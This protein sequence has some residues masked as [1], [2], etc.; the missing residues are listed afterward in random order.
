[1]DL[2][3]RLRAFTVKAAAR[4]PLLQTEEAAKTALVMPFLREILLY[5]P[6]DPAEVVPEYTADY[7]IRQGGKSISRLCETV[8]P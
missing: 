6:N 5:D 3:E 2:A 7:G 4:A 1:M 8:A